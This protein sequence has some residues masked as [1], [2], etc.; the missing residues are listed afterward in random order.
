MNCVYHLLENLQRSS[1]AS[2]FVLDYAYTLYT[3]LER[4][5]FSDYRS[6]WLEALGN[7]VRY[8]IVIAAMIPALAHG[9]SSSTTAAVTNGLR[10]SP[11]RSTFHFLA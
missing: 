1:L 3:A 5:S 10:A 4:K 8:H 7:L 2:K 11:V 6:G 9:S